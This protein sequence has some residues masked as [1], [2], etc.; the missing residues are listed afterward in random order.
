[1]VFRSIQGLGRL[2]LS[3]GL[4]L[5]LALALVL[6]LACGLG[7]GGAWAAGGPRQGIQAAVEDPDNARVIVKYRGGSPLAVAAAGRP[8]HAARLGRQLTLAMQDGHVLGQRTQSLRASGLSSGQLAAR[9]AALPDVEWAVPARRKTISAVLPPNDPYFG[10]GQTTITPAVGQ[11][12]LRAPNATALSAVN[13]LGAWAITTGSAAMTVAVLD[14]G[15]VMTHPDLAGKLHPGYDFVSRSSQSADGDGRDADASDP[16]DWSTASDSCGAQHSTWHGTQVAGLIGAATDNGIGMAGIGRNVMVLPVRVLGKCGGYDDD[17]IAGM[18]WASGVSADPVRNAHPARVLNLSLGSS[19][20][21]SDAYREAIAE[22]SAAGVVVVVAAGNDIGHAVNEP[23]NCAGVIAVSGVRHAGTKVGYSNL[24]PEVALAAP[25]GNCVNESGACLYP[26]LT[27]LNSGSTTP[28]ANIYSDSFKRSLGT[29][30]A[31]PMVAG[32]AALMLSVDG[33]LTPAQVKATL[34]AAAR[35]FPMTG[36]QT[37]GATACVAPTALDQI[38]CYCTTTTCG[39]GMLD[40]GVALALALEGTLAP[41]AVVR[42]SASTPTVGAAV[43]LDG[44]GSTASAG[45]SITAYEWTILSGATLASWVGAT[46]GS[47][48][49]LATL[50]PGAVVV[51]LTVTDS[52]QARQSRRETI[53]VAALPVVVTPPATGSGGGG[54]AWGWLAGLA[55]AVLA[56]SRRR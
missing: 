48:A 17:I 7:T 55:L 24:G 44:A 56:L 20:T 15:V 31:A 16:G 28:G 36:A 10:D 11:W 25:A 23:A 22:V 26:L 18:R 1:M 51:Q 3:L 54:L 21:C 53:T 14:T 47:R 34:Q 8:Q 12:Y 45:R 43:T 4:S 19:G 5:R 6:G 9:L 52:S 37:V 30:F 33:S 13:A 50:A 27:T 35:A 46:D 39:A 32:T 29:S 49:T 38:E 42:V 40:A 41:V 2:A